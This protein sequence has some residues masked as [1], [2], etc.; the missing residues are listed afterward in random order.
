MKISILSVIA[1]IALL[2]SC[3][4]AEDKAIEPYLR[5]HP[6]DLATAPMSPLDSTISKKVWEAYKTPGDVH[7][8]LAADTGTWHE[9]MTIWTGPKDVSP[10]KFSLVAESTM[11]LGGRFQQIRHTGKVMGTD[12]EGIATTGF[13]NSMGELVATWMDNFGTGIK[14]VRGTFKGDPKF[15]TLRGEMIDP[16]TK[17]KK[18]IRENFTFIDSD[19]RKFELFETDDYNN[20]YK[21]MEIIMKRNK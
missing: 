17:A 4:E 9:E 5:V 13:D 20:E 11:I 6:L 19:T 18:T 7:Q 15:F 14:S 2:S 3:K 12:F 21:S 10:Q 1:V 8:M 16:I